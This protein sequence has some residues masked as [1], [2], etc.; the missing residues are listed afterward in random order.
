MPIAS[1]ESSLKRWPPQRSNRATRRHPRRQPNPVRPLG[2]RLRQRVEPGHVHRRARRPD[3]PLRPRGRAARRR[4]RRRRAQA[5]PR[6]QPDPRVRAR[7][8]AVAYTPAFDLQQACGTGLQATIAVANG[9]A[10]G[11]YDVAAAG[12]VDTTSDAPSRSATTCAASC[13]GCAGRSPTS[14]AS[15]WLARCPPRSAS[16]SRPTASPAP[17]CRWVS[18]PP[19]PPSRWASSASTR[20]S[21]P[22]PATATWPPPTTAG[23]FDD[24]VTPFLGLYRDNNLRAD[25]SPRSS[26]SSGRCSG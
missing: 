2:R 22:R 21:W 24:L 25:S 3:R 7:Q 16:R 23:F 4:R 13:S 14:T 17:G 20:T 9:I 5:Q 26:P 1:M 19:S 11:Q 8:F 10:A 18:T 6:L 15:S 12:G